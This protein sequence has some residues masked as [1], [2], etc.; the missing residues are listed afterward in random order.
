MQGKHLPYPLY[1]FLAH[2]LISV[3]KF[4][5]ALATALLMI[6]STLYSNSNMAFFKFLY[7]RKSLV[8]FCGIFNKTIPPVKIGLLQAFVILVQ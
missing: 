4:T 5:D 8:D 7:K 1:C 2:S 3:V 6:G